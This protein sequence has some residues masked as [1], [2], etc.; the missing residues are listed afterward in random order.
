[1]QQHNFNYDMKFSNNNTQYHGDQIFN[2]QSFKL[3]ALKRVCVNVYA[4]SCQSYWHEYEYKCVWS[5]VC[6]GGGIA[7][8]WVDVIS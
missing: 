7:N 3:L 5:C 2:C 8:V 6:G 1:M 4:N